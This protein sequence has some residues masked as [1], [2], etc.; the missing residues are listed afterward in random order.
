MPIYAMSVMPARRVVGASMF[1][2]ADMFDYA[3]RREMMLSHA[4]RMNTR[5]RHSYDVDV[6]TLLR[7]YGALRLMPR[8]H[9]LSAD[10]DAVVAATAHVYA[11][12]H[13]L[14]TM[15]CRDRRFEARFRHEP[16]RAACCCCR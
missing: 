5:V 1:V 16:L 8:R 3:R 6:T 11:L 13:I 9:A 14:F 15:I 4:T 10:D 7:A 12:C 2:A